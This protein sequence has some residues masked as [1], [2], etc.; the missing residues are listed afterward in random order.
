MA[1]TQALRFRFLRASQV[2]YLNASVEK[3]SYIRDEGMLESA[4]NS[5]INQQHYGQENDPA[6]LA[7]ALSFR[8]IKNHPFANGNKRTAL[9]AANLFLLQ[10]GKVLLQNALRVEENDT[11]TRAHSNVAMDKMGELELAEI[12][13]TAWQIATGANYAQAASLLEE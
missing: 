7:A 11:I 8:L 10:N 3:S 2:K 12:Y 1:T 9:L 13:R 6:R 4:I 5:P